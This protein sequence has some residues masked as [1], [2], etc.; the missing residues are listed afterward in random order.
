M[1]HCPV[2]PCHVTRIEA[3]SIFAAQRNTIRRNEAMQ[4]N[5]GVTE[6]TIYCMYIGEINWLSSAPNYRNS[7]RSL[8]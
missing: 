4:H 3:I 8:L 6:R 7:L 5:L 1:S 2:V